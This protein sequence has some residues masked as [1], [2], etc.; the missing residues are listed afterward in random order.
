MKNQ[1]SLRQIVF[2]G[3]LILLFWFI[4]QNLLFM[5]PAVLG[6]ITFYFLLRRPHQF[7]RRKYHYTASKSSFI[8][9]ICTLTLVLLPIFL[10]GN[11]LSNKILPYLADPAPIMNG[12]KT[13]NAY[14][15][16]YME[17][18]ILSNSALEKLAGIAQTVLPALLNYSLNLLGNTVLMVFLLWFMLNKRF[19]LERF[20]RTNS[21]FDKRKTSTLFRLIKTNIVSNS[22]G[23]LALGLIQGVVAMIGYQIFGID[24]AVLWGLITGAASVVPF[25]GTML[26]WIP[27]AIL[28]LASG[29]IQAGIGLFV[30]GF[31]LIGGSDNVFRFILQKKLASTHPLITVLGVIIGLNL[32]GFWGLIFGPLLLV[33]AIQLAQFY[34]AEYIKKEPNV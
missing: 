14:I 13:I 3:S 31:I 12:L 4:G 22:M 28:L 34:K 7:L 23:I 10:I 27:L 16:Q 9:L 15:N 6:A 26:A 18:S 8:L 33:I 29:Q 17:F 32:M 30:Y 25:V 11:F 21:P 20:L 5:M 1:N 19:E 24:E 2:L